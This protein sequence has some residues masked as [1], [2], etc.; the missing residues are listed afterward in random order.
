MVWFKGGKA[1][2]GII[3]YFG[4]KNAEKIVLH[5][6]TN[7]AY[8]GYD[9][10]GMA[11]INSLGKIVS[12]KRRGYI[13]EDKP[14][15]NEQFTEAMIGIGNTRWANVIE[16]KGLED[17]TYLNEDRT[18][19]VVLSGVIENTFDIH[20][21]LLREGHHFKTESDPET[22][23]HLIESY[24]KGDFKE[25]VQKAI[26]DI[27][28]EY[29]LAVISSFHTGE[30]IAANKENPL[31]IGYN[32]DGYYITTDLAAIEDFTRKVYYLEKDEFVHLQDGDITLYNLEGKAQNRQISFLQWD[33]EIT[34][35]KGYKHYML[36]EIYEQPSAI[37]ETIKLHLIND[38]KIVIDHQVP[39]QSRLKDTSQVYIIGCGT[40]YHAGLIGKYVI[41]KLARLPVH[42]E[43]G[44]EFRYT[45]PVL[46]KNTLLIAISESGETVDT[47][48]AV[49]YAKHLNIPTLAITNGIS[50]TL[51]RESDYVCY[52]VAGNEVAYISTKSYTAQITALYM[53]AAHIARGRR[54]LTEEGQLDILKKIKADRKS[55][56]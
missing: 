49:R 38:K 32:D 1:M 26:K 47:L 6:L 15:L 21:R 46:D 23:V 30:L 17:V 24:Y 44:S 34:S 25:A 27:A 22:I 45:F 7:L 52:T 18:F 5:G 29:A 43:V 36:K 12:A 16:Q 48:S 50:S 11:V 19:A 53:V 55:V 56:V 9:M 54:V 33:D 14:F 2:G 3:G 13:T 28:G 8:K 35:K 39:P 10:T 41:E 40:S 51:A 4:C 42:V 20:E 31:I 37:R